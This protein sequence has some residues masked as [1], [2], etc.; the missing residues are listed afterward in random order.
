MSSVVDYI[1]SEDDESGTGRRVSL[2]AATL[3]KLIQF[4][5]DEFG[6]FF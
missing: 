3:D 5:I 2:R 1:E 4:C 6:M